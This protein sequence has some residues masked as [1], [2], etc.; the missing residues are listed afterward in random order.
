MLSS[1]LG[2]QQIM[3]YAVLLPRKTLSAL[4]A[5]RKTEQTQLLMCLVGKSKVGSSLSF[6]VPKRGFC[7]RAIGFISAF[8]YLAWVEIG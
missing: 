6:Q 8:R 1:T 7:L 2:T 5:I 4:Y 3:W